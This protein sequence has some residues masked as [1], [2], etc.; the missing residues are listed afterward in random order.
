M[1]QSEFIQLQTSY[2]QESEQALD[3]KNDNID[4]PARYRLLSHHLALAETRQYSSH[5]IE[6]LRQ[7]VLQYHSRLYARKS[8][9]FINLWR[10]FS[11]IFPNSVR[12]NAN[13]VWFASMI[14]F[15]PLVLSSLLIFLYPDS[16]YY[17]ISYE[18]LA[19]VHEMYDP[20]NRVL[21]RERGEDGD[22][23]MFGFYLYNNTS[24][25]FRTFAAGLLM[26]VG[27]AF[28]LLFNAIYI[29]VIAGSIINVGYSTT[30]FSFVS[31]HSSFELLAIALSGAAGFI[32]GQS[33]INPGNYRRKKALQLAAKKAL[34]VMQGAMTF[35]FIAA[36]IEA[37]W[38]SISQIDITIKVF[39]GIFL[40]CL[41]LWYLFSSGRRELA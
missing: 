24:I 32:L 4:L 29:G 13:L 28:F 9:W 27:S 23:Y 17:F 1:K 35:F 5:L 19:D 30:F 15:L 37:F 8:N 11:F 2:W 38:S 21:G 33:L 3:L 25:G 6:Y 7:L 34:P 36:L 41:I 40:W 14:F 20:E 18:Q 39:V 31:G 16:A 10:F 26:G 12:D 22:W